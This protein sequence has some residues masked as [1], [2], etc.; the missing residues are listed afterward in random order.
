MPLP[1]FNQEC[2]VLPHFLA[3]YNVGSHSTTLLLL[4]VVRRVLECL[5][6]ICG[7][8]CRKRFDFEHAVFP[9]LCAEENYRSVYV[10]SGAQEPLIRKCTRAHGSNL[11]ST[12]T[13]HVRRCPDFS[14][15]LASSLAQGRRGGGEWYF[16]WT[17]PQLPKT[18]D[19]NLI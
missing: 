14:T 12:D 11:Q 19:R 6:V 4:D 8:R 3:L 5:R 2:P 16:C 13:I 10:L 17:I 18:P 9:S 7:S 15:S 1:R